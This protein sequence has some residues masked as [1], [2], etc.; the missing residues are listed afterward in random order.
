MIKIAI[1]DDEELSRKQLGNLVI[2]YFNRR[3]IENKIFYFSTGNDLLEQSFC[4]KFSF[5]FLDIDLGE[6]N[7]VEIAKK[8]RNLQILQPNI[9]FVTS[10]EEFMNK[11][12]SI[13]T[14]DYIIKPIEKNK[15]I[16]VLDNLLFWHS[17]NVD[18]KREK[19]RFKTI[20]GVVTLY[21]DEILY[22]EYKNRRVDI[23]TTKN[24]YH[25][26]SKMKDVAKLL[27]KYN[28]CVPHAAYVVNLA[29]ID[30][31]MKNDNQIFMSNNE[32]IP[33]SQLKARQFKKEYIH[34]LSNIQGN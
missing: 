16:K 12:L 32:P 24:I 34:F 2:D 13:H 1:C 11:V 29:E 18:K 30:R 10:Y 15:V 9:V 28:F 25:M 21:L 5:I 7:G 26:Y 3:K 4:C 33:I 27:E 23:V 17:F 19:K 14:F 6:E 22:F 8:I 31:Y 20:D